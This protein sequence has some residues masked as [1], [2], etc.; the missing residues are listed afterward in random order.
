MTRQ[1]VLLIAC[2]L[3]PARAAW[4]PVWVDN[5]SSPTLDKSLWTVRDNM[6]HGDREWQLYLA[7][8]VYVEAGALVIRTQSRIASHGARQYN[9]TSGWVDSKGS[10]LGENTYGMFSAS[11]QLPHEAVGVWPAYWIVDDNNHC[12]PTGGESARATTRAARAN[13][14][15]L[16]RTPCEHPLSRHP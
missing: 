6:T 5:F 3:A 9:F 16:T 1:L 12:W 13:P 2:A 8:E 4:A 14:S 11:I 7:D 10:K 15:P